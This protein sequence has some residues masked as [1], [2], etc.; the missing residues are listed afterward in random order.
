MI[1]KGGDDLLETLYN[2]TIVCSERK[3]KTVLVDGETKDVAVRKAYKK[4]GP[5]LVIK[6]EE[7]F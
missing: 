5:C 2:I 1:V 6:T 7:I 4:Y 3:R